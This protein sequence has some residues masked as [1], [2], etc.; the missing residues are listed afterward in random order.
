MVS[1]INITALCTPEHHNTHYDMAGFLTCF[2][3][4]YLPTL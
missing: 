1:D 4:E 3:L 2:T